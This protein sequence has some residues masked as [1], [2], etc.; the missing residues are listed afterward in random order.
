MFSLAPVLGVTA[1]LLMTELSAGRTIDDLPLQ[2]LQGSKTNHFFLMHFFTRTLKLVPFVDVGYLHP[3]SS[4]YLFADLQ[5]YYCKYV[6]NKLV[7]Y[8]I[9]CLDVRS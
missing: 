2:I 5:I 7:N 9:I 3:V 8:S 6:L 1:V 4:L